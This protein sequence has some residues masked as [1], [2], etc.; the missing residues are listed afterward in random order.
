MLQTRLS[1][2]L[3]G[4]DF[5]WL[6]ARHRFSVSRAGIAAR[7]ERRLTVSA[8]EDSEAILAVTARSSITSQ[9]AVS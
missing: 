1:S 5:G 9:G 6:R 2:T 7:E 4:G 3:D 8:D